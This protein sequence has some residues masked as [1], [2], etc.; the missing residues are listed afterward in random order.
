MPLYRYLCPDDGEFADL[1][2]STAEAK[3]NEHATPCPKCGKISPRV[4]GPVAVKFSGDG[5]T[6]KE[7]R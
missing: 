2:L 3:K 6:A 4:L 1:F 7:K 5:W